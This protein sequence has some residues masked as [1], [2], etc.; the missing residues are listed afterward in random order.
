[1]KQFIHN[2][3]NMYYY[4]KYRHN[5]QIESCYYEWYKYLV[6]YDLRRFFSR[7]KFWKN[8]SELPF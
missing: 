6:E 5:E 1:M 4:H 7:F 3:K 8:K 2:L